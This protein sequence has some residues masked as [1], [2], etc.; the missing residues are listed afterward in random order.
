MIKSSLDFNY[1][2]INSYELGVVNVSVSS[3]LYEESFLA[4]KQ[5]RETKVRGRLKPYFHSADME[6]YKFSLII[7]FEDQLSYDQIREIARWLNPSYYKPLYF[8]DNPDRIFYCIPSEEIQI[9]HNGF[10]Q[11]YLTVNFRC[12][13]PFAYSPVFISDI[14]DLSTNL[15]SGKII[16]IKN[17]GDV[18]C[19]PEIF[20]E[21]VGNGSFSIQN[22]SNSGVI[23]DFKSNEDGSLVNAEQVYVD[24]E[25]EYISTNLSNTYRYNIFN[26]N[27]LELVTGR[28]DL[29]IKG[30]GIIQFRYQFKLLQ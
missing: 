8:L 20:I 5:I 1:D 11:G 7:A 13:S 3:S 26:N 9:S 29:L 22:L 17:D 28:N 14:Y 18:N 12:D 24:C 25:N 16:T 21:K 15:S 2:G 27:Y 10:N 4:S 30:T 6:P 23:T 19:K